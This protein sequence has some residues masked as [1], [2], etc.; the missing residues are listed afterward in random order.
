M[1]VDDIDSESYNWRKK[2]NLTGDS[3]YTANDYPITI[4]L[5]GEQAASIEL[6][7]KSNQT[8]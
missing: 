5:L 3:I 1:L 7:L 8:L 2:V 4:T 6:T